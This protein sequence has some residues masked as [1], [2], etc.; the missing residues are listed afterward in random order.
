MNNVM[1]DRWLSASKFGKL[2]SNVVNS[3]HPCLGRLRS[4]TQIGLIRCRWRLSRSWCLCGMI[5]ISCLSCAGI[6]TFN[7]NQAAISCTQSTDEYAEWSKP[8]KETGS[9]SSWTI[10]SCISILCGT[11]SCTW[12]RRWRMSSRSCSIIPALLLLLL[13]PTRIGITICLRDGSIKYAASTYRTGLLSLHPA[14]KALE[15]EDMAT[16]QFLWS[17]TFSSGDFLTI[18]S[19]FSSNNGMPRMHLLSTHY[20]YVFGCE[21]FD[22]RVGI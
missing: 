22:S 7:L 12:F 9:F 8:E 18:L 10:L 3:C 6:D 15:M 1:A 13:L 19:F 20:A 5:I 4:L 21:I 2:G 11:R 14:T 17:F 16:R